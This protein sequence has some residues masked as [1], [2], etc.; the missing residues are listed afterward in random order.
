VV[1]FDGTVNDL[2][3]NDVIKLKFGFGP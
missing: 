2:L 1:V 3:L